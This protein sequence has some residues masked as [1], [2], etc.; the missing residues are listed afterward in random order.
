MHT[1]DELF[2]AQKRHSYTLKRSTYAQRIAKLDTLKR[3]LVRFKGSIIRAAAK[4][5]NKPESEVLIAEFMP[6][7][8]EIQHT[9][10][11]LKA[12]MKPTRVRAPLTLFGTSSKILYE[13]K[14]T[15]LIIS[16]WNYPVFLSFGPLI[17]AIAAGCTAVIKPSEM[18]PNLSKEIKR[19]CDDIFES[20]EVAVVEGDKQVTTELLAKPFDH[21]FFT[22]SPTVGKIVMAAAAKHL[23]SVTLELGGKSPVVI[24]ETA[25]LRDVAA[26]LVWAKFTN[27]GQTCIAPDY[28]LV[29]ESV[30]D[31]LIDALSAR[32][33]E[34][35]G[36]IESQKTNRDLCR[37]VN[38]QHA[39]RVAELLENVRATSK[40]VI[41]GNVDLDDRYISPTIIDSP[42]LDSKIMSEEIFGPL[43]PVVSFSTIDEALELIHEK[44]KPLALYIFSKNR[45]NIDYVLNNTTAGGSCINTCLVHFIHSNLPVGGVNNSG[46]GKSH[47]KYG[48]LAFSNERG[49]VEERFSLTHLLF[50]PYTKRVRSMITHTVR[51]LSR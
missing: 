49:V 41:G 28:L 19:L 9:Q 29:H 24:D 39:Q 31:Q 45:R 3:A 12:W 2:S 11:H 23:T 30:K 27:N 44:P 33:E 38:H 1:T 14:G 35:Y 32:I 22:G 48:F 21:I 13:P 20:H 18:T 40:R 15:S 43:L 34:V 46:I 51:W 4:D 17:S 16:P 26:R 25:D 8:S 5:F 7:F 47:G 42:P 6:L 36:T 37:I 10:R 50:A